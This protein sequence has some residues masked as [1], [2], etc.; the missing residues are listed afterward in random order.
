[1]YI[2]YPILANSQEFSFNDPLLVR[3]KA[4]MY[5][6]SKY[7]KQ[8]YEVLSFEQVTEESIR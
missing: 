1:M 6:T 2:F 7:T 4:I 8:K 5:E 3:D